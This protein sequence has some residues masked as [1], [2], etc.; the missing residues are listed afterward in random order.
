MK[1]LI[2]TQ[3]LIYVI[4]S[5]LFQSLKVLFISLKDYYNFN[6]KFHK[7]LKFINNLWK[8]KFKFKSDKN[9]IVTDTYDDSS[10][11][12]YNLLTHTKKN[13]KNKEITNNR[14]R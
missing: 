10:L 11:Y 7:D 5:S 9:Y 6:R 8:I 1:I 3:Y 2:L 12:C 4:L 14:F 13:T